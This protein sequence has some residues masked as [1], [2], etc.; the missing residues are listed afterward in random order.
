MNGKRNDGF[1]LIELLVVIAIIAILAAL[2]LPTL[3]HAKVKAQQTACLNNLRQLQTGW[4]MYVD[5]HDNIMPL[6][7]DFASSLSSNTSTTNA[8]VTGDATAAADLSYIKQGTIYS[9]VGSPGV[10]HCP[11]DRSLINSSPVPRTRSY[12]LDYYLHGLIDPQYGPY[13]PNF[14]ATAVVK[15]SGVSHP[16]LTFA[17]L[18]ENEN[19]IEDGVYLLYRNPD[20]TWQ[21]APSDRHSR[22]MNLSFTDGHCEYWKWRCPKQTQGR[23]EGIV[24]ND[25]LQDLRRLQAALPNAP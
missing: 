20:E 6:N 23:G 3:S 8:W 19:T 18:D 1:T 9:Y 24:S 11:T 10:Y 25:D 7:D 2:L 14:A 22:G 4:M 12:S 16:S 13:L 17:F 15:Y 5:D 21:N